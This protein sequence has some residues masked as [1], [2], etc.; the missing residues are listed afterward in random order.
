MKTI[1][2]ISSTTSVAEAGVYLVLDP[3]DLDH[4]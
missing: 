4:V 3:N 2:P 1:T